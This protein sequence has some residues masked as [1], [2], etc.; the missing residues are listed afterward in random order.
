MAAMATARAH[1]YPA[2]HN[3]SNF[4]STVERVITVQPKDDIEKAGPKQPGKATE[5]WRRHETSR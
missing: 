5:V 3:L 2:S 1:W 4:C